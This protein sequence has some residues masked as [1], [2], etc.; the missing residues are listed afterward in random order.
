MIEKSLS[1]DSKEGPS[2]QLLKEALINTRQHEAFLRVIL[3]CMQVNWSLHTC[4]I[5]VCAWCFSS[6]E[7]KA[8]SETASQ[9]IIFKLPNQVYTTLNSTWSCQIH[10]YM[11]N[12]LI[13]T[14]K[15]LINYKS[16][17]WVKVRSGSN[18]AA[19]VSN[20]AHGLLA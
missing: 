5:L 20:V 1:G 11:Y 10:S 7:L 6:F 8:Y 18:I 13:C 19:Q 4:I 2:L 16:L 15:W 12:N 9:F 3:V 17:N 14:W